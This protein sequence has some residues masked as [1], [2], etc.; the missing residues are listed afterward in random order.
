ALA[1]SVSGYLLYYESRGE[2]W[3][4]QMLLKGRTVAGSQDLGNRFLSSLEPFIYPR[5]FMEHP[6]ESIA[7]IK[8]RIEA[9]IGDA[10]N[11]K[12]MSGGI[13]DIE[14]TVQ[15]LQLVN[16]GRNR[17][18][19]TV[20]TLEAIAS[21]RSA[22]LLS[23][24]EAHSLTEAYV[25]LRTVEHRLQT[26]HN[27][28]RHTLPGD[29]RVCTTLARRVGLAE[30]KNLLR[31]IDRHR[32]EVR[33][34]FESVMRVEQ[35]VPS[36]DVSALLDGLLPETP[37]RKLLE[38]YGFRDVRQAVRDLRVLS[39]GSGLTDGGDTDSRLRIGF[40]KL[41]G[42]V[43]A[44]VAATP[45]AD[46]TLH[47]LAAIAGG[48]PSTSAFHAQL[49]DVRGRKLLVD[50]ASFGPRFARAL[51]ADPTF[52]DAIAS[53]I[54]VVTAPAPISLPPASSL[55]RLKRQR[56]LRA[57]LRHF[58]GFSSFDEMTSELCD[59]AE[60]IV[61]RVVGSGKSGPPLA[62]LAA[63]K[64][65]TREATIDADLDLL[66]VTE[67]SGSREL[68]SA[69]RRA[70]RIIADLTSVGPEGKLYETD[71]RLRPEGRNAPL[72]VDAKRYR[73]YLATR[74]SLWERQM[75]TRARFLCGDRR[76]G[77]RVMR[78]V[79]DY[80]FSSP[81]PA[82]WV[83]A[84]VDMRRKMETRSRTRGTEILDVKVGPGGMADVEFLV[85]IW[86]LHQRVAP[87]GSRAVSALLA[88][89]PAGF[90]TQEEGEKAARA[91]ALYRRLELLLRVTLEE[92]TSVLP[93]GSRLD[94][95]ARRYGVEDGGTLAGLVKATM[96]DVRTIFL[97][98]TDRLNKGEQ[99]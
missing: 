9:N 30:G 34:V 4:R 68:T 49:A 73:E 93:T 96:R 95:L 79:A 77:D 62:V 21:L 80:T 88:A 1:R 86:M 38:R 17:A 66:F 59:L 20:N 22:S 24:K 72:V 44:D 65:G 74:A 76:L 46:L 35:D 55:A 92:R 13:R 54:S 10:A 99:E 78:M 25:F 69:E 29:E 64:L 19:R 3:E 57:C 45:D 89:V 31:A 83:T 87:A 70:T 33:S 58:L 51:A 52:L 47:A 85:Q 50:I 8:G 39:G 43:L 14:F 18:I 28:Q 27:T 23:D 94:L 11:V 56:E 12:L 5:T 90:M 32:K 37:A 63:G 16:G 67:A 60:F 48:Q 2:L 15:A 75:L 91:Y 40:R 71:L 36:S 42:S 98:V 84:I 26:M 41:A 61:A 53:D 81:L 97:T 6:A 82:R 7:R